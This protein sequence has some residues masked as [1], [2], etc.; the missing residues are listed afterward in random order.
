M[1]DPRVHVHDDEHDHDHGHDH[2]CSRMIMRMSHTHSHDHGHS[3]GPW[4]SPPR[5]QGLRHRLRHRRGAELGLRRAEVV[6]GLRIDSLAL[7]ADA[8]HNLGDVLGLLLAWLA[9]VLV[10]RAAELRFTYGLRG[11]RSWPRWS[12]RSCCWW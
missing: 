8:G 10:K 3:H 5:A 12:T 4:R 2:A 7:L 11:T 6:Y 9:S 1:A